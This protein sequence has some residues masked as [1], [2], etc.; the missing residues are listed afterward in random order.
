[1]NS[2]TD[3]KPIPDGQY[4]WQVT[5]NGYAGPASITATVEH[6]VIT[7]WV[8]TSG[9]GEYTTDISTATLAKH[10]SAYHLVLAREIE[11]RN[12]LSHL[13]KPMEC[14]P[15]TST[16]LVPYLAGSQAWAGGVV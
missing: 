3:P 9:D 11:L 1:M 16:A 2:V 4:T 8:T 6:N 13:L 12:R 5:T 14:M 10:Q 7:S 15:T